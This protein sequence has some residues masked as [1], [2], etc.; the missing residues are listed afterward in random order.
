[1]GSILV[2]L[3][4]L[5]ICYTLLRFILPVLHFLTAMFWLSL[6]ALLRVARIFTGSVAKFDFWAKSKNMVSGIH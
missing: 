4:G 5:A 6:D 2:V 3:A 1:M